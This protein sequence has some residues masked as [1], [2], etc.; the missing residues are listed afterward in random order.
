MLTKH[1]QQ[2][3]AVLGIAFLIGVFVIYPTLVHAD[4]S[5]LQMTITLTD[6]NGVKH[7]YTQNGVTPLTITVGAISISTITFSV[8]VVPTYTGTLSAANVAYSYPTHTV[9]SAGVTLPATPSGTL[10]LAS[11]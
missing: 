10:T 3:I 8:A 6:T 5:A 9:T 11:P 4:V 7:I 1:N 2:M